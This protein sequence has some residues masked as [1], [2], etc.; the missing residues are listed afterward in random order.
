[1]KTAQIAAY[2]P[3]KL[4]CEVKDRNRNVIA[5]LHAVYEDGTCTFYDTIESIK[6]FEDVKPILKPLSD[7]KYDILDVKSHLGLGNWCNY[8]ENYFDSWFNDLQNIDI[9][10]LRAPYEIFQ[11][12]LANHFDVF[13]L[14]KKELAVKK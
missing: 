14:I 5:E 4:M 6:G 13:G 9:L 11:F 12:F 1:M 10:I 7:F 3:Y 8:Y 2:L